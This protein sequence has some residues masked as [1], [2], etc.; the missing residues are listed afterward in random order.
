ML[1]A[2]DPI[3]PHG[4]D[5]LLGR[6]RELGRIEVRGR[7]G[8]LGKLTA[9][10]PGE[11][12]GWTI[13]EGPDRLTHVHSGVTL[14]GVEVRLTGR[15]DAKDARAI[16]HM[17][18]DVPPKVIDDTIARVV[19][20]NPAADWDVQVDLIMAATGATR[21]A[22]RARMARR[23]QRRKRGRPKNPPR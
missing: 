3:G 4:L 19:K 10:P 18:K 2:G 6:L 15:G 11:W 12:F 21:T 23:P 5:N 13:A 7:G 1:R 8:P 17:R 9:I 16:R 20:D 22:V 14:Y